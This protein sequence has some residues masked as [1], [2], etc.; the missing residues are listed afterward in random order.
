MTEEENSIIIWFW[1]GILQASKSSLRFSIDWRF[2]TDYFK[3]QE[4]TFKML[5]KLQRNTEYLKL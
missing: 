3:S 2:D 4:D 1:V 5:S